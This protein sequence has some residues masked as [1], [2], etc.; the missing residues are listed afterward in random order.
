M[1]GLL[2]VVLLLFSVNVFTGRE[3]CFS[4]LRVGEAEAADVNISNTSSESTTVWKGLLKLEALSKEDRQLAFSHVFLTQRTQSAILESSLFSMAVAR[5]Y[6]E[7][8]F[9]PRKSDLMAHIGQGAQL[10][11]ADMFNSVQKEVAMLALL[12]ANRGPIGLSHGRSAGMTIG[13]QTM[14]NSITTS[15]TT[16]ED[17]LKWKGYQFNCQTGMGTGSVAGITYEFINWVPIKAEGV[18]GSTRWRYQGGNYTVTHIAKGTEVTYAINNTGV[19]VVAADGLVTFK[20]DGM[21]GNAQDSTSQNMTRSYADLAW[22]RFITSSY[23]GEFRAGEWSPLWGMSDLAPRQMQSFVSSLGNEPQ[24]AKNELEKVSDLTPEAQSAAVAGSGYSDFNRG[25]DITGGGNG[26]PYDG[27][28][29]FKDDGRLV[30]RPVAK[31]FK[32]R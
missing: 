8:S 11:F 19:S 6:K 15:E 18:A 27:E 7:P 2:V 17:N 14:G 3:R 31:T 20:R 12:S 29:A 9:L 1:K 4:L 22:R 24:W 23:V 30:A 5:A 13:G 25:W 32:R 21:S 26:A 16:C 10:Y 28:A